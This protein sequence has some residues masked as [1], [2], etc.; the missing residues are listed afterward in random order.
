MPS[1]VRSDGSGGSAVGCEGIKRAQPGF[2]GGSIFPLNSG[3]SWMRMPA[4]GSAFTC[5]TAAQ[6]NEEQTTGIVNEVGTVLQ[7]SL[8]SGAVPSSSTHFPESA[9]K[10]KTEKGLATA[11]LGSVAMA[12]CVYAKKR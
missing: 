4:V 7:G 1:G 2:G 8:G 5:R 3:S 6:M 12:P 11:K 9:L 10:R